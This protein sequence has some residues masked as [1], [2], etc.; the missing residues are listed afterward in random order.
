MSHE[1]P[2]TSTPPTVDARLASRHRSARICAIA[3]L[4]LVLLLAVASVVSLGTG[5][6]G[7]WGGAYLFL[8]CLLILSVPILTLSVVIAYLR[9]SELIWLAAATGLSYAVVEVI[10]HLLPAVYCSGSG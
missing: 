6:F 9:A 4:V 8:A 5:T 1:T 3:C 10:F 7:C 2:H